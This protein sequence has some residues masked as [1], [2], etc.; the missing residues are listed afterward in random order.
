[1]L[2]VTSNITNTAF[3]IY[4][5]IKAQVRQYNLNTIIKIL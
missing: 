4:L 5:H 2:P 3:E 1:M